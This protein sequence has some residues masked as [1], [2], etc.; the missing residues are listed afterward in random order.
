M[1]DQLSEKR[2]EVLRKLRDSGG[3]FEAKVCTPSLGKGLA[4]SGLVERRPGGSI[5]GGPKM[6][7]LLTITAAGRAALIEAEKKARK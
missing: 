6:R 1:S 7:A 5:N 3:C 4:A 2:M